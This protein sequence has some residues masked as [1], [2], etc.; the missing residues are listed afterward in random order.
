MVVRNLSLKERSLAIS[1]QR[2]AAKGVRKIQNEAKW[3]KPPLAVAEH[4]ES[5]NYEENDAMP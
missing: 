1:S 4:D 2:I 3:L 5:M